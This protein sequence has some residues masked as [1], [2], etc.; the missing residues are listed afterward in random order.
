MAICHVCENPDCEFR[1]WSRI[2]EVD[3]DKDE[4]IQ[5]NSKKRD[6]GKFCLEYTENNICEDCFNDLNKKENRKDFDKIKCCVFIV[7]EKK[8][9]DICDN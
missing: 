8:D 9:C 4:Y 7:N 1:G 6:N 3:T 5:Q 2:E